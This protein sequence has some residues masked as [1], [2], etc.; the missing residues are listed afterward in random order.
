MKK[1]IVFAVALA[2]LLP[3]F[4]IGASAVSTSAVSAVLIEAETGT[5]LYDKNADEQRAMA[6]TTK[7]MTAI[8]TIEAGD[9]DREFTVDDTAIMVEG[10]SMGLKRGDRVS[11]RDLLYGILLPSGN[12]AANAAAVS[13]SGS[14]SAFVELMN[15]KA[16]ELGLANTHF[17]TPSGLD[18]QGHYTTARELAALTAYA[19]RNETFR[20]IVCRQSAEVEFGNPPY[21]RTL[22]NS[23]K[24]LRLYG[25]AVGVKTG[26]TDNARRCLVSAAERDGVTLIAVTLNAPDDWNDHTKMLDYGFT[27]VSAYPL[28]TGCSARVAVAGTGRTV[29]VYADSATMALTPEQ[30][31][32]LERRVLL[33]RM[34]YNDVLKGDALGSIEFLLDGKIIKSVPL[35]ADTNVAAESGKL[36]VWQKILSVF[37]IYA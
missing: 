17:A 36:N 19:M 32:R 13:V 12:D 20:E 16:A 21:K 29:G 23:N 5:V 31:T 26:F 37:G 1:A 33:P 4:N 34:V 27:Q 35:Y 22:Y 7:I 2:V 6:S 8:L 15:A 10:T 30:R 18:A 11:R 25:G 24:M 3:I 14:I 9:L 28:E